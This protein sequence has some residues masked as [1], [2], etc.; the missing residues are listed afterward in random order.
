MS[1]T[2]P[3]AAPS[4]GEFGLVF[5]LKGA[6]RRRLGLRWARL[7]HRRVTFGRLCD[8]HRGA[9][10]LVARGAVARFGAACVLDRGLT[11]EC[12]GRIDVGDRTV[13]GHHCTLAASELVQI[14]SDCL[15]AEMVSIRD[16][17]HAFGATDLPINEQGQRHAPVR[18][19][20]NV[21]LGS[22]VTVTRGLTIGDNT[23]VGANAVVTR[24]LPPDSI[25]VGIPARV[26][27][28]RGD[29][30]ARSGG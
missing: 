14:G 21:W 11:V 30:A 2:N 17:D 18:I 5:R 24:D 16:H 29:P 13:F 3:A 8:V 22:K 4:S 12:R 9:N 20:N 27:G 10:L 7:R 26:V 15:I 1:E 23:I 19:G 6:A 25:A 28:R